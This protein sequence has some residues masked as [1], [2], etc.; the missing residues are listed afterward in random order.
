MDE[1]HG[2]VSYLHENRD[3]CFMAFTET[4]FTESDSDASLDI[5]G[6]RA[7]RQLDQDSEVTEITGRGCVHPNTDGATIL[8][9]RG[10]GACQI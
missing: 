9:C 3:A 4:W 8:L 1:L 2:N 10:S 6:F 7:P 5:N